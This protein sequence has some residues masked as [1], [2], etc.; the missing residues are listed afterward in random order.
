LSFIKKLV[1]KKEK[2]PAKEVERYWIDTPYGRVLVI[3]YSNG[4][5]EK[6]GPPRGK[7]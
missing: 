7:R 2:E 4:K 5:I 3:R 6:R 1:S